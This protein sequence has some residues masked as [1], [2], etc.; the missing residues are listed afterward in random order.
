M[1]S[2]SVC[3]CESRC[4]VST[5]AR[6]ETFGSERSSPFLSA[7]QELTSLEVC[8]CIS[9]PECVSNSSIHT[10]NNN[11]VAEIRVSLSNNWKKENMP[12]LI[13]TTQQ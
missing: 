13:F 4:H 2:C 8:S 7:Q 6:A 5:A 12:L 11:N 10:H 9:L 3:K 1:K